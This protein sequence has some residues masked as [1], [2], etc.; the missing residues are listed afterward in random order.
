MAPIV[1]ANHSNF[2]KKVKLKIFL[3]LY[4]INIF[5]IIKTNLFIKKHNIITFFFFFFFFFFLKKFPLTFCHFSNKNYTKK[6]FTK[7]TWYYRCCC[8]LC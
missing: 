5:F 8:H 4:R 2:F 7:H 6:S 3:F 1:L